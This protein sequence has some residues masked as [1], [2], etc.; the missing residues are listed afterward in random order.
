MCYE[1][2]DKHMTV[3]HIGQSRRTSRQRKLKEDLKKKSRQ[4]KL[5]YVG[6]GSSVTI[7]VVKGEHSDSEDRRW[8][9]QMRA[10]SSG[11]R[12]VGLS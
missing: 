2:Y 12:E 10:G 7:L 3:S 8:Q 4:R 6:I 5:K 1:P 11:L 9:R